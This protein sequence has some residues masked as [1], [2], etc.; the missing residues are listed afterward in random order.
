MDIMIQQ[1][2]C[3]RHG[4]W[5]LVHRERDEDDDIY[6]PQHIMGETYAKLVHFGERAW[7]HGFKRPLVEA[8][9]K[10]CGN[11]CRMILPGGIAV[12]RTH[13]LSGIDGQRA[14]EY[15]GDRLRLGE[16]TESAPGHYHAQ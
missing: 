10:E 8:S 11:V 12:R 16:V 2:D 5:E 15:D 9:E 13:H 7:M 6:V 14:H 4:L 1:Y 3:E